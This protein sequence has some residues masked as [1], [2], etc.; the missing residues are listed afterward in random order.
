MLAK[1]RTQVSA[2]GGESEGARGE[3]GRERER[4][5]GGRGRERERAGGGKGREERRGRERKGGER[6]KG[7]RERRGRERRKKT[8]EKE[9]TSCSVGQLFLINANHVPQQ[10]S[11]VCYNAVRMFLIFCNMIDEL[12]HEGNV[13]PGKFNVSCVWK[14]MCAE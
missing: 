10:S 7:E 14:E 8:N 11:R 5:G 1:A 12:E 13:R 4:E 9:G 3:R 6:E 2:E